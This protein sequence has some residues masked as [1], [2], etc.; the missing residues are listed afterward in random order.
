[1]TQ[2]ASFL[3]YFNM[4]WVIIF[5]FFFNS[6]LGII[7]KKAKNIGENDFG[8]LDEDERY[9]RDEY[10][11]R[12]A[13][14]QYNPALS[15]PIPRLFSYINFLPESCKPICEDDEAYAVGW[16]M[17]NND[18]NCPKT[19]RDPSYIHDIFVTAK[20]MCEPNLNKICVYC[21]EN[22]RHNTHLT[23]TGMEC[24]FERPPFCERIHDLKYGNCTCEVNK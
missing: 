9:Y 10:T 12:I 4:K 11:G 24:Q 15:K 3:H 22:N 20:D 6:S 5:I 14:K 16:M 13:E 19:R 7:R 2:E 23:L 18:R 1:M 8:L 21:V 17:K